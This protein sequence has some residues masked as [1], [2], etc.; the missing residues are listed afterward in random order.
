MIPITT[1]TMSEQVRAET[2][3]RPEPT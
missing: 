1:E 3:R 2:S